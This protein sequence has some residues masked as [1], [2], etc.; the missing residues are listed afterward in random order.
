MK[1]KTNKE[2]RDAFAFEC[3]ERLGVTYNEDESLELKFLDLYLQ[4]AECKKILLSN[5]RYLICVPN[6]DTQLYD[7][8]IYAL[9]R[10]LQKLSELCN[11]PRLEYWYKIGL[12]EQFA[13][14]SER[15]IEA[16]RPPCNLILTNQGVLDVFANT[17]AYDSGE[18]VFTTRHYIGETQFKRKSNQAIS[19]LFKLLANDDPDTLKQLYAIAYFTV[20]GQGNEHITFLT[21]DYSPSK[22]II[23]TILKTLASKSSNADFSLRSMGKDDQIYF[24]PQGCALLYNESSSGDL[25]PGP[26]SKDHVLSIVRNQPFVISDVSGMSTTL[27]HT[28]MNVHTTDQLPD[29]YISLHRIQPFLW[30][31]E[32]QKVDQ[33]KLAKALRKVADVCGAQPYSLEYH[34]QFE[35]AL[36][37]TVLNY[38]SIRS[39][40]D[41]LKEVN[42]TSDRTYDLQAFKESQVSNEK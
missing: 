4:I 8:G 23:I 31:V 24:M 21:G 42:D 16:K 19:K 32:I 35:E 9:I 33:K 39:Y 3:Y 36:I 13:S 1:F 34:P 30:E 20:L 37:Q 27:Q 38:M 14:A 18:Y 26:T 17:F 5:Q 11:Y 28:G 40:D 2:F 41:Y 6:Y 29:K 25:R 12:V 10:Q 22:D 7:V 15:V